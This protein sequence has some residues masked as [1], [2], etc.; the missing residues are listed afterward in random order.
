[1]TNDEEYIIKLPDVN[2][3]PFK[4]WP[5]TTADIPELLTAV[6]EFPKEND[7][8]I[9]MI[10]QRG[11]LYMALQLLGSRAPFTAEDGSVSVRF[12]HNCQIDCSEVYDLYEHQKVEVDEARVSELINAGLDYNNAIYDYR[13][14]FREWNVEGQLSTEDI[15]KLPLL[16]DPYDRDIIFCPSKNFTKWLEPLIGEGYHVNEVSYDS[17][18][19]ITIGVSKTEDRYA[20]IEGSHHWDNPHRYGDYLNFL[21]YDSATYEVI[22]LQSYRTK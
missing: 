3:E 15:A 12:S 10:N 14:K 5:L 11:R 19:N 7:V 18:R 1:M 13:N 16:A 4:K 6:Q 20:W 9:D 8:F 21:I 2:V 22:H 17:T